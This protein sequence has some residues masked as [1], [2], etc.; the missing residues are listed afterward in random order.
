MKKRI[1]A[2]WLAL[3]LLLPWAAAAHAEQPVMVVT[4]YVSQEIQAPVS[5]PTV[6]I[7]QRLV[8]VAADFSDGQPGDVFEIPLFDDLSLT[9]KI[10]TIGP[11]LL[12]SLLVR[13]VSPETQE[14]SGILAVGQTSIAGSFQVFG[15]TFQIRPITETVHVVREL[16]IST[17]GS[18]LS[19]AMTP[20]SMEWQTAALVNV[21]RRAYGLKE[22]DWDDGLF[23]AARGHSDD[24]A[25]QD[26]FGHIGL[27]GSTPGDRIT[28]AGYKWNTY[29]ESI[30]AGF[31]TPEAIME[32]WMNSAGHRAY[33]LNGTF[34]DIGVGYAYAP[35]TTYEHYWT[36]NFGRKANVLVCPTP[37]N[38]PWPGTDGLNTAEWVASFYVAYWGRCPDPEGR[39]FWVNLVTDGYL[40]AIEVAE[41]FALTQEAK[42][43]YAY[44][45]DPGAATDADRKAFVRQVYLNLLNREPD[46]SGL[47]Y[48][49]DALATGLVGP[50]QVIGHI[51]NAAMEGHGSDWAV[52]RNKVD[53]GQY[54]ADRVAQM[55]LVWS[56]TLREYAVAALQE[57]T[58]DLATV[59]QA[60]ALVDALL[61]GRP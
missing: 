22:L 44:L 11:D 33:I 27:D 53:V 20:L 10:Q 55:E 42:A 32:A 59:A 45:N 15:R 57:V 47:Q 24:M 1:P 52:I 41:E 12:G 39:T 35:G 37:S 38:P 8:N 9:L 48:W 40:S 61:G 7:R 3:S 43:L 16:A 28:E 50:G 60:M 5:D 54:F 51:I 34:C 31:T 6:V 30:A 2:L 56:E 17:S 36:Q 19:G 18:V 49:A 26:Y 58:D 46:A 14:V 4:P 23:R 25:T 13:G 21:E 29:G